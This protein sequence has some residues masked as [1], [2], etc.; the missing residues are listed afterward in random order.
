MPCLQGG[1]TL[2]YC[3]HGPAYQIG[4][5]TYELQGGS[6]NLFINDGLQ[7]ISEEERTQRIEFYADNCIG[8]TARPKHDA[9]GFKEGENSKSYA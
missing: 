7:I 4:R 2:R 5:S 8:W 9:N 1:P 6:A 3:P